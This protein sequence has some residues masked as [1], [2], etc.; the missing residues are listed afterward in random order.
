MLVRIVHGAVLGSQR[1][2]PTATGVTFRGGLTDTGLAMTPDYASPKQAKK[3]LAINHD[4]HQ[5]HAC[6][7][8]DDHPGG[9][10]R[11]IAKERNAFEEFSE[12]E[13][14]LDVGWARAPGAAGSP[15]RDPRLEAEPR[16]GPGPRRP[17]A[18]PGSG[19]PGWPHRYAVGEAFDATS[20]PRARST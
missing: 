13:A 20:C 8:P 4:V 11:K 1:M 18:S 15:T 10:R 9:P 6:R 3:D 5:L 19:S 14:G 7:H 2:S 17:D 12:T 16:L